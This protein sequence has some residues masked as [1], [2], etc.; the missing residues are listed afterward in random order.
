[1]SWR[2]IVVAMVVL[3]S[4]PHAFRRPFVGLIVFSWLAYMRV[5]DLCWGFA[6]DLRFSYYVAIAMFA[7][8]F[9]F[10]KTKLVKPDPRNSLLLALGVLV[11]ISVFATRFEVSSYVINY[12]LEFL[13]ILA[14][15]F[16]TSSIVTTRDRLRIL[17]WT[18]A[19][20]LGFFG[21]KSGVWGILTGGGS[22][23]LRGPGGMLQDNNDFSLALTMNIPF[24]F[25]LSLSEEGKWVRRGL[26]GAVALS[27]LTILLTHSRGGFLAMAAT[28][29]LMTWR[30][31]NR[32]LGF[33]LA[34]LAALLLVLFAP[35]GVKERISSIQEF[36]QDS[37]AQARLHTWGVAL[38]IMGANPVF[39]VGFR[40]F[41]AA[42]PEYDPDPLRG[43]QGE[44]ERAFFV[45]HNSYLQ[46]GAESGIPA[47]VIFLA[48]FASCFVTL[49]RIRLLAIRRFGTG[50]ILH[51][52]RMF[53]ASLFGFLVGATFL[54]RAHFDFAYHMISIVIAFGAIAM[55]E[56]LSD[57]KYPIRARAM[58]QVAT[59]QGF[60]AHAIP[61][62]EEPVSLGSGSKAHRLAAGPGPSPGASA[63][64][65]ADGADPEPK[66]PGFG[67]VDASPR[68][69][70]G[71]RSRS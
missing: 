22:Q 6:R 17:V 38:R 54:N 45:A 44:G 68:F 58:A 37:S 39:G 35:A 62:R 21:V 36:E 48:I 55:Q 29:G 65:L 60:S 2:D 34:A 9:L 69:G 14:I 33:A 40:N 61:V 15:T 66:R 31:R 11:S 30:S 18:I 10:E 3:G 28:L 32:V 8:F 63:A 53:E 13:K 4:L 52:A 41:Q 5:Q 24:L 27:C 19:L 23:I 56:M 71:F 42:Y 47:L 16:L 51:Y 59:A 1:M 25:Y 70:T 12:Y 46:M 26:L 20:S 43:L 7:G 64:R 67:A 49:R 57:E 50:W